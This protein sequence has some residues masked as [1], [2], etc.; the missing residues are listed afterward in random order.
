MDQAPSDKLQ[1][2]NTESQP[3]QCIC[4][5]LLHCISDNLKSSKSLN[6]QLSTVTELLF[7]LEKMAKLLK[8]GVALIHD[9]NDVVHPTKT[10]ILIEGSVITKLGENI[11]PPDGCEIIDCS[12]KII[13]PGFVDTHHHLWQTMLKGLFGDATFMSYL[14]ISTY[15]HTKA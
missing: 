10:D 7:F 5:R 6:H 2:A 14:S 4:K 15:S 3:R 8:G 1:D 12:D 9:D 11:T 13:S